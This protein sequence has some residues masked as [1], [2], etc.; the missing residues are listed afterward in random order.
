M[1]GELTDKN[2][3]AIDYWLG[4]RRFNGPEAYLK[5]YPNCKS[6][7]AA[8]ANMARLLAKDS[9]QPYIQKRLAEMDASALGE[10]VYERENALVDLQRIKE[11]AMSRDRN[12][13]MRDRRAAIAAIDA[14]IRIQGKHYDQKGA[15]EGMRV[16]INIDT[17]YHPPEEQELKDVTPE[18]GDPPPI[19]AKNLPPVVVIGKPSAATSRV[20]GHDNER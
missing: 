9:A 11:D 18:P 8:R 7:D 12:G 6:R 1:A 20:R 3:L 13:R 14:S 16:S 19:T 15:A 10:L 17:K 4:K 5:A 2:R